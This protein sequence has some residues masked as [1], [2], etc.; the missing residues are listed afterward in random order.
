MVVIEIISSILYEDSKHSVF[1]IE[2]DDQTVE[3]N[4]RIEE[5]EEWHF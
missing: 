3:Q 2:D 1:V 4:K 5:Y